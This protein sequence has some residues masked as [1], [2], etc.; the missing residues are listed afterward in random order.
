[1]N[2]PGSSEGL[3]S[4]PWALFVWGMWSKTG[5]NSGNTSRIARDKTSGGAEQDHGQEHYALKFMSLRNSSNQR[6]SQRIPLQVAVIVR[7]NM[8]NGRCLQVQAFTTVVNAHGGMLE[9]PMKLAPGQKIVLINPISGI[10]VVCRVVRVERPTSTLYDV[11]FEF[12]QRSP[13]FWPLDFPPEDWAADEVIA[14]D[15]LWNK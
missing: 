10:D 1:M 11:V 5:W 15:S 8:P 9:S 13:R 6:R 12:D 7:A 14:R 2:R 3:Y 4:F